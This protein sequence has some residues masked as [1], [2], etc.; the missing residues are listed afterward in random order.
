VLVGVSLI[1]EP[2]VLTVMGL[3]LSADATTIGVA[4]AEFLAGVA[5]LAVGRLRADRLR[6]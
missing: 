4:T 1:A 5:V 2:I 6:A 3:V